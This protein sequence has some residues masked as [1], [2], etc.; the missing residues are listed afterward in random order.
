MAH[1][2][3]ARDPQSVAPS[4]GLVGRTALNE[5]RAK[6]KGCSFTCG[7]TFSERTWRAGGPVEVFVSRKPWP[8]AAWLG[9]RD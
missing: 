9:R 5:A 8:Y 1:D 4:M 6:S 2:V 3:L 7:M